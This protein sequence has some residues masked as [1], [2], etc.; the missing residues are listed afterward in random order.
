LG[1][2]ALDVDFEDLE[3]GR[4]K[5]SAKALPVGYWG[6]SPKAIRSKK[7][8]SDHSS[9]FGPMLLSSDESNL[10]RTV[11]LLERL[12]VPGAGVQNQKFIMERLI[13][14]SLLY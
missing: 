7:R 8:W 4:Q 6:R 5:N 12:A 11:A 9:I 3:S 13:L 1:R 2:K 10:A 14:L